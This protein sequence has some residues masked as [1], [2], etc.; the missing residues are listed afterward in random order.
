ML[1]QITVMGRIVKDATLNRTESGASV[2]GFTVAC[3][4]DHFNSDG[5]HIT[6]FIDCTAWDKTAERVVNNF[7]KGTMC[8]VTG[9]LQSRKWRDRDG[10]NRTNWEIKVDTIYFA[11]P[12][13]RDSNAA[14]A[15][16]AN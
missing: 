10:N 16:S 4:R 8:V 14:A 6:D 7:P 9:R 13:R 1:N 3:D 5:S 2:T 11:E 12:K 15:E